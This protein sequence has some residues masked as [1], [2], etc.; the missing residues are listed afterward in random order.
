[1][2]R[3][4]LLEQ[5]SRGHFLMSCDR[6]VVD[7]LDVG[8]GEAA[9]VSVLATRGIGSPSGRLNGQTEMVNVPQPMALEE[10]LAASLL[11][12]LGDDLCRRLAGRAVL[13]HSS[14]RIPRVV[15]GGRRARG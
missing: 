11:D 9:L 3:R 4:R 10:E 14:V 7:A 2:K 5:C 8:E 12:D 1:E 6:R 13:R 15:D